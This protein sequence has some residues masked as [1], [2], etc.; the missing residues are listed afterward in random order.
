MFL[1]EEERACRETQGRRPGD[2]GARDW[3]NVATI[4]RMPRIAEN[5]GR[6]KEWFFPCILCKEHGSAHT[7]ISD[8]PFSEQWENE[9]LLI[10]I[11]FSHSVSDTLL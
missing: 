1:W 9:F 5:H 6:G 10:F 7:L 2:D 8:F 4:Q 11:D 3:S